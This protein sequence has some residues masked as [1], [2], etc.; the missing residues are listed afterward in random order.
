M[1]RDLP[2]GY[3][4]CAVCLRAYKG[5]HRCDDVG[6][7][8]IN[9]ITEPY[10]QPDPVAQKPALTDTEASALAI[11]T[12]L[13]GADDWT[14]EAWSVQLPGRHI[15]TPDLYSPSRCLAVEVKGSFRLGSAGRSRLAFDTARSVKTDVHWAWM[16]KKV[17]SRGKDG[18]WRI[19][20][21]SK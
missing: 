17:E 5:T 21:Y 12:L 18:H 8:R 4:L 19:E 10:S 15:Y 9:L 1:T 2:N 14:F 11:L 16:E 13:T 20:W 6:P 7:S 3:K